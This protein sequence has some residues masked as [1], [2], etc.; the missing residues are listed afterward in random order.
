VKSRSPERN[1]DLPANREIQRQV[2]HQFDCPE[3]YIAG[4]K[5]DGPTAKPEGIEALKR[6]EWAFGDRQI[7]LY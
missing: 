6:S 4:A 3:D 7:V 5:F 2:N 1:G